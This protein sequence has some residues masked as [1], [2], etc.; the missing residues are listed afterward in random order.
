MGSQ[1]D[2]LQIC[3]QSIVSNACYLLQLTNNN[4]PKSN[5][6]VFMFTTSD[7]FL[8]TL[9]DLPLASLAHYQAADERQKK[10]TKPLGA[11]GRLEALSLFFASWQGASPLSLDKVEG[12]LFAGNHGIVEEGV[13]PFPASVTKQMVANFEAGGAAINAM[14]RLFGHRLRVIPL[15]LE[16]PTMNF[17]KGAALSEDELLSAMNSGA[18]AVEES[19][20]DLIYFGEM[21][22]GNTTSA[23][24]LCAAVFGGVGKDWAGPGTG[25]S[26]AGVANKA[27]VIDR[28]MVF[29][30]GF[31]RTSFEI[32]R[33]F[34]GR[35]LAA[36]MGGVVAA[37]LKRVPVMLDGFVAT[38][39]AAPLIL[40]GRET[41]DHCLAAHCSAE[42]GHQR[43]LDNLWL[44]P[45]LSLGMR[46]GEGTGAAL[47]VSLCQAAIATYNDMATFESAAVDDIEPVN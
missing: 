33:L 34:G 14:T 25:L 4:N 13:T 6:Q 42:P 21:G 45:L 43:L 27:A 40:A 22:I 2:L 31:E 47:A 18:Q 15:E 19:D 11:L 5:L 17:T 3:A 46:L 16:R 35:E 23:A 20:A 24:A 30:K 7:Q 10:L 36:I 37:R 44:E 9:E 32:M 41:L 26:S 8:K 29:H 1:V 28:A 38:A 39:A 12:L